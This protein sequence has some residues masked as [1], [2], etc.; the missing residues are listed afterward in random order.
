MRLALLHLQAGGSYAW[1]V[2][3]A[4]NVLLYVVRGA[5]RV[6]GQGVAARELLPL[7]TDGESIIIQAETDALLLLGAAAPLDEP[8]ARQGPFVMN[9]TTQLMEAMRDY[10]MG[11]MGMLLE[12]ETR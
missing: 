11:R 5:A 8:V 7:A 9:T 12:S 6:N 1:A 10:Q 2:A 4:D 3:A